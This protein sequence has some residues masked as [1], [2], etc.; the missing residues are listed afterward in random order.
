MPPSLNRPKENQKVFILICSYSS[1]GKR[2]MRFIRSITLGFIVIL[3]A[4]ATLLTSLNVP[5]VSAQPRYGGTLVWGVNAEPP[6]LIPAGP[7]TWMFQQIIQHVSNT[8]VR[9][10]PVTY[11]WRPELAQSWEI[12]TTEDGRMII[13]FDLVRNATWHDGKPF[14]SADVKFTMEKI[15]PLF[16]SFAAEAM[17]YVEAIETPDDYTIIFKF[18]EIWAPILGPYRV[19]GGSGVGIMPKHLYEDTDIATNPY[20]WKPIGTGPFKFKEWKKGEYIIFERNENYW[21]KGL[22]YLDRIIF[23]II[24][25]PAARA[26]AFEKGEVDFFWAYGLTYPDAVRLQEEIGLGRLPGKMV[27]FWPSPGGSIDVLI[28]NLHPEGP[29]PFKDVRVRKA[30]AAAIDRDKIAEVVYLGRVPALDGPVPPSPATSW[31]YD[32]TIKQQAYDPV[33]ANI[34]LDEAGYKRGPDGIRFSF[35]LTIDM[36]GYPA[37]VKEAELIR[38][39]LGEVGI[40]VK[41]IALETA[42]WHEAVFKRWDFDTFI[43]PMATGPDPTLLVRYFTARGIERVSWSNA[44]GYNNPEVNELLYASERVIDRAKR[45][46]LVMAACRIMVE[47]QAAVWTVRRDF[48]NAVSLDFSDEF[49]PGAWENAGGH[50]NERL[51]GVYWVKAPVPVVAPP[52]VVEVRPIIGWEQTAVI[53][54]AIVIVGVF[55]GLRIRRVKRST[56]S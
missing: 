19:F 47:D 44:G 15:A 26:L 50:G 3:L 6:N 39:M 30:I 40:E 55:I 28:F 42:A 41:I 16:N 36:V 22:P 27:W 5:E 53:V 23:K 35:R 2:A 18:K 31:Y 49:Q 14:T 4:T 56:T 54:A 34:L 13:K 24:P 20:N 52:V 43:F 29:A 48:I 45:G 25:S 7:P 51:E 38:D 32:P 12:I 21:K 17:K 9:F 8:L 10:D 46:E 33:L 11:E 37:H 1:H